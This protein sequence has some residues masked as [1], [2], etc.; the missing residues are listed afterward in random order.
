M[1]PGITPNH[2]LANYIKRNLAK[3]YTPDALK[4][5]LLSQ[6]YGRTSVEKAIQLANEQ[7]AEQAPKHKEKPQITHTIIESDEMN[8]I[9]ESI[10]EKPNFLKRLWDKFLE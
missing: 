4:Y 5:S 3:G 1:E 9:S 7:M 2:Q 6:G 10:K 8:K